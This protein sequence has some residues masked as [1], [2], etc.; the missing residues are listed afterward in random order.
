MD[1]CGRK[2]TSY[3]NKNGYILFKKLCWKTLLFI[4]CEGLSC[5]IIFIYY[6]KNCKIIKVLIN[7]TTF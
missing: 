1:S 5:L 3:T 6:N 4:Y 7:Y 2:K